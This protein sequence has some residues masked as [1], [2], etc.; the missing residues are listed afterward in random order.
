MIRNGG[1][2]SFTDCDTFEGDD[3][4]PFFGTLKNP[5]SLTS[6]DTFTSFDSFGFIV[7]VLSGDSFNIYG[8]L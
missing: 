1:A 2:D 7:T 5:D 8:T 6:N 3:S 4:F